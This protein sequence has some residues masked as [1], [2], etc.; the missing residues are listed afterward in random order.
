M[1]NLKEQTYFVVAVV[2]YGSM[3]G[4]WHKTRLERKAKTRLQKTL[5]ARVGGGLQY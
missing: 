2:T 1:V 5:Q 4:M 3:M